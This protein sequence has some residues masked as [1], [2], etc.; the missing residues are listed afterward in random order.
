V[1]SAG[2]PTEWD[3]LVESA[4][5][6]VSRRWMDLALDRFP[7]GYLV[8][9]LCSGARPVAALGGTVVPSPL[10][11]PRIDPYHVL[12][13]RSAPLGLAAEGPHPWRGMRPEAVLPCCLLMYP[14]Y[15][16]FPVGELAHDPETVRSLVRGLRGWA[17][18]E[19]LSSLVF[20]YLTAEGHPLAEVLRDEG[21]SV[22]P[23]AATCSMTVSWTGFA[24]YLSSLQSK[25]RVTV[26][27]ELR[28]L[29]ERG[30]EVGD[31]EL[32]ATDSALAELLRLR[33]KLVTKYGAQ[34]APDRDRRLLARVQAGFR[35]DETRVMTARRD[36]KLLGFTLF[37]QDGPSWTALLTGAD[38]DDP[39]YRLTYFATAFYR[40]AALA[41]ERGVRRISY[42]LGSW[43]AKRL[44]GCELTPLYAGVLAIGGG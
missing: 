25:R 31:E 40:P 22:I 44:R 12:S 6:S 34:P 26:R 20:L 17:A 18:A 14:N 8:F 10:P 27:H 43:E 1:A 37:A 30:I 11:N 5:P 35:P 42:G 19:G 39:D 23:L 29:A 28:S 13:G 7:G 2:L 24:G 36:G 21:A 3:Q 41:P 32:A 33:A 9:T 4:P 15:D 38:Y 16:L